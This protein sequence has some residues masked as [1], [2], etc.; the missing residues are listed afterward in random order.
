MDHK[1]NVT[2]RYWHA[3]VTVLDP[4]SPEQRRYVMN[5][6]FGSVAGTIEEVL[7]QSRKAHPTATIWN[8]QHRGSVDMG[9]AEMTAGYHESD[10]TK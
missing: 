9:I 8:I 7:A 3:H 2:M 1:D 6:T 10:L 5:R 4:K